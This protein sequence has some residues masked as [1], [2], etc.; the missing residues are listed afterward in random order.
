MVEMAIVLPLLLLLLLGV[1][2][3]GWIFHKASQ[4]N[5]AARAGVRVAVRPDATDD[6]VATAVASMM[7]QCGMKNSGYTL[8]HSDLGVAVAVPVTVTVSVDYSKLSLTRTSFVPVPS[9]LTGQ[10]TMAKEGPPTTAPTP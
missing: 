5:M 10:G 9:K 8:T 7:N 3:Y 2:E 1:I 4:I 6:D